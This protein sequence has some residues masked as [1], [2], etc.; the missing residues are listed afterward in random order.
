[1]QG[2]FPMSIDLLVRVTNENFNPQAYLLAN[3][4]VLEAGFDAKTHFQMHGINESRNQI[5]VEVLG[6]EGDYRKKKYDLFCHCIDERILKEVTSTFPI[7]VGKNHFYLNQYMSESANSDFGPFRDDILKY[8]NNLYLDIG[9]GLRSKMHDNCLYI[10]VYPSISSDVIVEPTCQYPF[11]DNSFDGIGCFAVL[12]HTRRPWQVVSEIHRMLKPG[13]KIWIDWPFLQPVHGYPSHFFNA[14]REGLV[15]VFEDAGFDIMEAST[16]P[17]QGPE[18]AITWILNTLLS[19]LPGPIRQRVGDMSISE[20]LSHPPLS[21]F[22][23]ELIAQIDADTRSTL[24][25]GNC[26][27]ANKRA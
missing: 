25:C 27:I 13:G 5:N 15:S 12:E 2:I 18:Y 26:L 4:D 16:R 11:K 10:E 19:N 9:C 8:T 1:M 3:P 23:G 14:T 20:L 7:I 21:P 6:L 24:A 17:H 22:W